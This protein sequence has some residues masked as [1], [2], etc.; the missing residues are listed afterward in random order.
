MEL[1][2]IFDIILLIVGFIL[3]IKGADYFVDGASNVAYN[4][5]IPTVIVGLT[6]VAFGTSAPEL[7]TSI[8]FNVGKSG[9]VSLGNI[10]GSNIFNILAVIGI[11]A[12]LGTLTVDKKLIKR[13][14]PFLVISSVGFLLIALKLP[15]ISSL[16][17]AIFLIIIITYV[18]FL[19]Q[20]A[21][22]DKE[23]MSEKIEVKFPIKKAWAWL[24]IGLIGIVIGSIFVEKSLNTIID[25]YKLNQLLMGATV[26]A[27]ATS[28][29]E[30]LASINALKKGDT[31]M[32]IGN[33]LGSSIFNILFILG[34]SS[35]FNPIKIEAN[36][37]FDI[38]FM[39][40]VTI[41]VAA[42]AYTK[43]EIDK[44]EGIILVILYIIYL[45]YIIMKYTNNFF[46]IF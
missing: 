33:A 8:A 1:I 20:E 22:Q 9:G 34:V 24:G 27:I 23:A 40:L 46:F 31:G 36:V 3:I 7:A 43:N 14:F 12:L 30:L 21:K 18:Y 25:A 29:P 4:F 6:I 13:D 5:N 19:V 44:K 35:I 38:F 2:L 37:H 45:A 26:V 16:C 15:E 10:I 17:G 42:F 32:V 11:S 28:M 41:I 39:A